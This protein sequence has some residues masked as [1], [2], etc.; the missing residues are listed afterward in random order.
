[1][2]LPEIIILFFKFADIIIQTIDL[3]YHSHF[4][5]TL[6]IKV[7]LNLPILLIDTI[8]Q[9]SDFILIVSL[10]LVDLNSP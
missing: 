2:S 9:Y 5:I 4:T 1:M 3:F 8:I 6:K 10:D 7:F